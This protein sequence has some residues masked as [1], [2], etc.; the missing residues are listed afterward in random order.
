MSN[1]NLLAPSRCS[2]I[3]N[4]ESSVNGKSIDVAVVCT[5]F[6]KKYHH[7]IHLKQHNQKTQ[8]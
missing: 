5:N 3:I 7:L 8:Q 4:S 2:P 6:L 1:S